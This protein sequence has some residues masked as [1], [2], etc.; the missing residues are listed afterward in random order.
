MTTTRKPVGV[1]A[2]LIGLALALA[3]GLA[4]LSTL[5]WCL[6]THDGLMTRWML[7]TAPPKDTGLPAEAY[8]P[9]CGALC[10]YLRGG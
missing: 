4:I 5:V 6:G 7:Q 8:G 10:G 9:L 2:F 1:P 3:L